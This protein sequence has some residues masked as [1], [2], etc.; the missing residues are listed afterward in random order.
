MESVQD[1]A[2]RERENTREPEQLQ[3]IEALALLLEGKTSPLATAKTV[4]AICESP[5][6]K[7]RGR[8]EDEPDDRAYQ[9]GWLI[10]GAISTFGSA[11]SRDRLV[12]LLVEIPTQPDVTY[13]TSRQR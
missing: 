13:K 5:M 6:A 1:W 12:S 2:K 4:T 8:Y 7:Y 10:C 11:E 3:F 9:L